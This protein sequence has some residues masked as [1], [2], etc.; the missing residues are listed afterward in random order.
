MKKIQI[1]HVVNPGAVITGELGGRYGVC[2]R[3][4]AYIITL[5]IPTNDTKKLSKGLE[6]CSVLES[7]FYRVDIPIEGY[8]CCVMCDEPYTMNIGETE[9]KRLAYSVEIPWWVWAGGYEGD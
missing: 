2:P 9:D 1:I 3:K 8:E 4:G 5:S 7:F 6:L